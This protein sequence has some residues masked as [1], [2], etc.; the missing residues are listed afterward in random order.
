MNVLTVE[1]LNRTLLLRQGLLERVP[2]PIPVV[3]ERM[4]G[5]QNQYAPNGYIALWSRVSG[6]RREHLTRALR[7]RR[8]IQ[9][10]L[11]RGTIHLVS[12]RDYHPMAAGVR[13]AQRDWWSRIARSRGLDDVSYADV[14]GAVT[15][16]LSTG[17]LRRDEILAGLAGKGFRREHWEGVAHHL[18]LVRVPPSGTWE[19]RRADLYALGAAWIGDG[20][21]S[22]EEG[23][24]LLIRRYLGGFGPAPLADI[25][26]W[27]GVPVTDLEPVAER[28]RLRPFADEGGGSLV[29]LP[30]APLAEAGIVAPPRFLPTWDAMLLA[31]ARRTAVLSEEYRPVVFTSKNPPS[32]PTFIV[33]GRVAGW[34]RHE[35]NRIRVEPFAPIPTR[36]MREVEGEAEGLAA[37]HAP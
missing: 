20:R 7:E 36:V 5:I 21:A 37:L 30:G 2:R 3:I 18:D 14:A 16:L 6:F 35:G 8:V 19:R 12:A 25:A 32:V 24:R 27:A 11:M 34:W 13:R 4:G 26:A 28:M 1:R 33:D 29:D 9:A 22:E 31:H 15:E 10:T 17:P 23:L